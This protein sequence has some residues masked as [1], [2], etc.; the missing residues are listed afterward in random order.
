MGWQRSRGGRSARAAGL[1][2]S[3]AATMGGD[4]GDRP[5]PWEGPPPTPWPSSPRSAAGRCSRGPC[6]YRKACPTNSDRPRIVRLGCGGPRPGDLAEEDRPALADRDAVRRA[7]GTRAR[8][9]IQRRVASRVPGEDVGSRRRSRRS[10]PPPRQTNTTLG[11]DNP[12]ARAR[13]RGSSSSIDELILWVPPAVPLAGQ[14]AD[15]RLQAA[16]IATIS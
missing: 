3:L 13:P 9:P 11:G 7:R 5:A 6:V 1:R 4:R 8:R 10:R 16:S 2:W 12:R 14:E 15:T